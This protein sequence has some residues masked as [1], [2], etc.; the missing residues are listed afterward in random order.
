[1]RG[2]F[3]A[4]QGRPRFAVDE[5]DSIIDPVPGAFPIVLIGLPGS[6][7]SSVG[8]ILASRLG[9][10]FIDTDEAV[11]AYC[12]QDIAALVAQ[13]GW[14]AFRRIESEVLGDALD[15]PHA[16]IAT[17]GGA[18]ES[19]V[20]RQLFARAMVV[21]LR[22]AQRNLLVRL[23]ADATARPLLQGDL[24]TRLS[25]LAQ[26]RN[27]L[28]AKLASCRIETDKLTP[29]QTADAIMRMIQAGNQV[30]P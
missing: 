9:R 12:G 13:R 16:V 14:D 24:A 5:T 18:V 30:H 6:G 3:V 8:A 17:G 29:K 1:M 2:E 10:D 4:L 20:N 15:R 23:T 19:S 11:E 21:W 22:A 25:E 28:Y 27:P 7:K 26:A